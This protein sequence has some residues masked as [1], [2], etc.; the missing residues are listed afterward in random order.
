MLSSP[1]VYSYDD[2]DGD[3]CLNDFTVSIA[4]DYVFE[5]L[6]DI[7][8]VNS[9]EFGCGFVHGIN[10]LTAPVLRVHLLPWSP[11]CSIYLSSPPFS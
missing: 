10:R 9:S 5:V 4:P 1:T 8:S 2:F 6:N 11:V 3:L 7:K